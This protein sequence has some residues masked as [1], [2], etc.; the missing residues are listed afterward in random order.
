MQLY[1]LFYHEYMPVSIDTLRE[2]SYVVTSE[3]ELVVKEPE[4]VVLELEQKPDLLHKIEQQCMKATHVQDGLFWSIYIAH[5]GYGEYLRN[6]YNYGKL[7]VR[8]KQQVADFILSNGLKKTNYQVTRSFCGEMVADLTSLPRMGFS[9]LIGMCAYYKS[10]IYIVD[11]V[12][13]TYLSFLHLSS[14]KTP[15]PWAE[16][17]EE[18][19]TDCASLIRNGV[20]T[21]DSVHD[22]IVLYKNPLHTKKFAS[23]E[24]FIDIGMTVQS[25]EEIQKNYYALEHYLKP[26]KGI[27][28]Y[29]KTDLE[30]IAEKTVFQEKPEMTIHSKQELYNAILMY[31][32]ESIE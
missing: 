28:T 23:N 31:L 12:K 11:I 27:S 1:H 18:R 32:S 5:Y 15:T 10:D 14:F 26:L 20:N 4:P 30:K 22:T 7:E 29:L 3:P 24:Y 19:R 16:M 9:G 21:D 8:E 17:S 6:K 13:H 25:I 2:Y